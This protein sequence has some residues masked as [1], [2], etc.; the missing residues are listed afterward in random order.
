MHGSVVVVTTALDGQFS[1]EYSIFILREAIVKEV[2][3]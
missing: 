3:I 2:D 1:Q